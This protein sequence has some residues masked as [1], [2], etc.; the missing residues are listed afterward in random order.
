M[1]QAIALLLGLQLA[2]EALSRALSLPIP[3]PVVG[4]VLLL[5]V[6][7]VLPRAAETARPAAEALLSRLALLFV[8]A[9]VGVAGHVDRLGEDAL[10]I[11]AALVVS[12]LAALLAGA[13]A[14]AL[15]TR[16]T[17]GEDAAEPDGEVPR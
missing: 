7:L 8:P 5:G 16:W 12:T 13:W 10:A 4:L 3:G 15:V 1:I 9:G 11:G 14:F 17:G 2:G 6:G